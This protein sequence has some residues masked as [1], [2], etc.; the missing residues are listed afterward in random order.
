MRTPMVKYR[1]MSK[2]A[3]ITT[4]ALAAIVIS[5]ILGVRHFLP[6]WSK[7]DLTPSTAL[8][9]VLAEEVGALLDNSGT[10]VLVTPDADSWG[11]GHVAG[12]KRARVDSFKR[13][14]AKKTR[15][16][17]KAVAQV[18]IDA[19]SRMPGRPTWT[20]EELLQILQKH[21]DC[22]ALVTFI[23]LPPLSLEA[24]QS[25]G[26]ALP[27]LVVVCDSGVEMASVNLLLQAG[28][29]QLAVSP[30]ALIPLADE[31]VELSSRQLV[32]RN[33]QIFGRR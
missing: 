7:V 21:G 12:W 15:L 19:E 11:K 20:A 27:K 3:L 31:T 17:I 23:G 9:E 13:H 6:R 33:F 16:K 5:L 8:G 32:E 18:A 22:G 1:S 26:D 29:V 28:K 25:Q 24:L 4:G 30:R 14:L 10:V 2:T